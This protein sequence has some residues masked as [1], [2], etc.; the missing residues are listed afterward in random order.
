[1]MRFFENSFQLEKVHAVIIKVYPNLSRILY[2]GNNETK[3]SGI[4]FRQGVRSP[5]QLL[6]Y[7]KKDTTVIRPKAEHSISE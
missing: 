7:I 5:I 6:Q 4:F 2:E 3:K 1:M